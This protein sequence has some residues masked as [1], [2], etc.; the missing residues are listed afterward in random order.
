MCGYGVAVGGSY[1]R[2][3]VLSL[4]CAAVTAALGLTGCSGDRDGDS[5][6]RDVAETQAAL[7]DDNLG[8]RT[9]I[10][11][12][13]YIAATEMPTEEMQGS[14]WTARLTPLGWSGRIA[15][16]EQAT[17]DV[18]FVV[19]VA[20]QQA[21]TFGERGTSAGQA[22]RCYRYVLQLYRFTEHHEIDCPTTT[23]TPAVPSAPV[24]R[25]P[26]DARERLSVALRTTTPDTLAAT[27]RAAFPQEY[28]SIDTVTDKGALVAAVGVPAERECLLLVRTPSGDI[29]SPGYDPVQLE[30]G[31]LGCS[32]SLFVSPPR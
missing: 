27:V 21:A 14:G 17:V 5:V 3:R 23:A 26:D 32:T 9:R 15:G 25:M 24:S 7:L 1:W 22:T 19:S 13:E 16:S 30:P 4:T 11:D 12:A 29:E 31:E 8:H 2:L 10:R 6:A 28:I 18:R 20:K